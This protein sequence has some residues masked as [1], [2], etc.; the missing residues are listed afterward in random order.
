M[1]DYAH[2]TQSLRPFWRRR[3]MA[4]Q[5]QPPPNGEQ[6]ARRFLW[7]CAAVLVMAL[8]IWNWPS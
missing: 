5:I 2:P 1:N 6:L 3:P 4:T 8:V 7:S